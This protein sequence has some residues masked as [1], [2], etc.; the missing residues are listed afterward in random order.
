MRKVIPSYAA[1]H[2]TQ[3]SDVSALLVTRSNS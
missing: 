3:I 1:T 2:W